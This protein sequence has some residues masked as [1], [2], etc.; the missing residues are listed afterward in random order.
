MNRAQSTSE[1]PVM[2][3]FEDVA[4]A[5]AMTVRALKDQVRTKN[6]PRVV[7]GRSWFFTREQ[8]EHFCSVSTVTGS[9]DLGAAAMERLR[10]R[11]ANRAA[12]KRR[13]RAR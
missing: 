12:G 11:V 13:Q 4:D 2:Y 9:A 7:L 5:Y 8:F 3:R 1:P 10:A 6:V